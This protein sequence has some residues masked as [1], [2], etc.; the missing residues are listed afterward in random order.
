M[1]PR[2]WVICVNHAANDTLVSRIRPSSCRGTAAFSI[3]LIPACW[4]YS[5]TIIMLSHT[6]YSGGFPER[7]DAS[8]VAGELSVTKMLRHPSE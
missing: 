4:P 2:F 3:V 8:L 1:W 6:H 5:F 7:R